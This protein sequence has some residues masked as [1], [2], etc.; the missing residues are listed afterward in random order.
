MQKIKQMINQGAL[1]YPICKGLQG[2]SV[3]K[4]ERK[5]RLKLLG[6]DGQV[7]IRTS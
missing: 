3:S 4:R 2:Q 5:G 7:D 1:P 6:T